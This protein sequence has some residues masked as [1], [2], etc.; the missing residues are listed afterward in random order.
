MAAAAGGR[1]AGTRGGGT[2]ASCG[3]AAVLSPAARGRGAG[4]IRAVHGEVVEGKLDATLGERG[5]TVVV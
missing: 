4:S 5:V 2:S 3:E 1:G